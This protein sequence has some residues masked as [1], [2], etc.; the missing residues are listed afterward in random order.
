MA[1]TTSPADQL[2]APRH[3]NTF[4]RG[5]G[6][7][8]EARD[9]RLVD[10]SAAPPRRAPVAEPHVTLRARH[11]YEA[12]AS[13]GCPFLDARHEYILGLDI[14]MTDALRMAPGHRVEQLRRPAPR[15]EVGRFQSIRERASL[16][17]FV[18]T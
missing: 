5:P 17:Q 7:A 13:R 10:G 8:P 4:Q 1:R 18:R 14:P 15:V 6:R 11:L 12:S 2:S 3:L 16:Y 9:L